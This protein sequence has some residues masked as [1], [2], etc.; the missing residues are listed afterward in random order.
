[1]AVALQAGGLPV[2]DANLMFESALCWLVVRVYSDWHDTTGWTVD[3]LMNKI[4]V[5]YWTQ[6]AQACTKILVVSEDIDPADPKA[7]IWAFATRNHP[8]LGTYSFPDLEAFGS[9]LETYHS[10]AELV[11][12]KGGL[13]IYNCLTLQEGL[14][15]PKKTVLSFEKNFPEAIQAK[16]RDNWAR[17]GFSQ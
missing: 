5:T 12:G 10:Q 7:V 14:G 2:I 3:Q 9:G 11:R 1:M 6:H 13:V 15:H 4:G 17:W 8:Q 16:V